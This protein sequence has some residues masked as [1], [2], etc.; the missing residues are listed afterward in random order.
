MSAEPTSH[1]PRGRRVLRWAL[2]GVFVV[3][4][5]VGVGVYRTYTDPVRVRR[6]AEAAI[7]RLVGGTCTIREASFSLLGGVRL[8]DVSIEVVGKQ[9]VFRCSQV[10]AE[11][12]PW[13]LIAGTFRWTK[14]TTIQPTLDILYDDATGETNLG[15]F[16]PGGRSAGS[17][18]NSWPTVELRD[19][20]IRFS[21][22]DDS[23]VRLL[24]ELTLTLRGR[25]TSPGQSA[26]DIVWHD[27]RDDRTG[28]T[29]WDFAAG[30]PRNI[31]GGLP[32]IS[33]ESVALAV[34]TRIESRTNWSDLLGIA[35]KVRVTDYNLVE[36]AENPRSITLALSGA[37][38]SVPCDVEE[39]SLPLDQR[40]LRFG[41]VSGEVVLGPD[42]ATVKFE[43]LFHGARCNVDGKVRRVGD[44]L[45][46]LADWEM[47][48]AAT[49]RSLLLPRG[50][51]SA[52]MEQ[53]RVVRAWPQLVKMQQDYDPH[54]AVDLD[55]AVRKAAGEEKIQATKATITARGGDASTR[56]FPYRGENLSG[57]VEYSPDGVKIRDVCGD[58]DQ[59]RVCVNGEFAR[60]DKCAAAWL[61]IT[62][63]KI[64]F[65]QELLVGLEQRYREIAEPFEIDAPLDLG[66]S[67]RRQECGAAESSPWD[68]EGRISF[69]DATLRHPR[70]SL[71][72]TQASGNIRVAPGQI[73]SL[74]LTSEIA[75]AVMAVTGNVD[76]LDNGVYD[77]S[78]RMQLEGVEIPSELD[79]FIPAAAKGIVQDL[80][81]SGRMNLDIGISSNSGRGMEF[82]YANI[83]TQSLNTNGAKIPVP[84]R[85]LHGMIVIESDQVRIGPLQGRVG[86]SPITL[87][88]TA[89][90]DGS[91]PSFDVVI[92]SPELVVGETLKAAFPASLR[93]AL[94]PWNI[95]DSIEARLHVWREADSQT[96]FDLVARLPGV[97][98]EHPAIPSPLRNVRGTIRADGDGFRSDDLTLDYA[99]T[100]ANV[101]FDFGRNTS[102]WRGD[103]S[104]VAAGVS[105]NDDL[106][107]A[108]PTMLRT[109]WDKVSPQGRIDVDRL[110]LL[111]E[112]PLEENATWS[113]DGDLQLHRVSLP[114]VAE[115]EQVDGLLTVRGALFD[116]QGGT[117]LGGEV[118]LDSVQL[119]GRAF[120]NVQSP[121]S[122]SRDAKG[123]VALTFAD[124][125]GEIYGGTVGGQLT[126][127]ADDRGAN[128]SASAMVYSMNLAPWID[129][130][131]RRSPEVL[132][133]S[134]EYRPSLVRGRA[135]LILNLSGAVG[136][137]SSRRGAGR[138]E[139][140]E[141]FLYRLPALLAVLSVVNVTLPKE[142][143]VHDAEAQ[144]Y[145]VGQEVFLEA[146]QMQGGPLTLVGSGIVSLP[147]QAVDL[148]LYANSTTALSHVPL[149]SDIIE[150]TT[151]E[152]IELRVT[153]PISRPTVRPTPFRGVS[154]ELK[155]LFQK[156]EKKPLSPAGR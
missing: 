53:Q 123:T 75:G 146:I 103:V 15:G 106:R 17:G 13:A 83:E 144:F 35:G 122:L 111:Y 121:W 112:R 12:D 23:S 37:S 88:G 86:G 95:G 78:Y 45:S 108:L 84:M 40:Y 19:A 8:G 131:R 71:P 126:L 69:K 134:A 36:T 93:E 129:A 132:E 153:G 125:R 25:A 82:L 52:P 156:K 135:N 32:A 152:L 4:V 147:D 77:G 26:Y 91:S 107:A 149:I 105:L 137:V 104:M 62:G 148:R 74:Y 87:E 14:L 1:P 133:G 81:I 130:G 120:T 154:E 117:A 70:L 79:S 151:K 85:S 142:E 11:H 59:G 89:S 61:R 98:V 76:F 56:W 110:K 24:E 99:E 138:V 67:L 39:R 145:L 46:S 128:Y 43:A 50:D 41:D 63:D 109:A 54:G 68:W 7:G 48:G 141:G 136:D 155:S 21:R 124:A 58:H 34:S 119:A 100:G 97:A 20:L 2:A 65:D 22:R 66:I 29:Q 57:T 38:L 51:A 30:L 55:V 16:Q 28:H 31:E 47:E 113:L 10:T 127:G 3:L 96:S 116:G 72:L 64:A 9:P 114:G 73:Q 60:P 143:F 115:V 33:M 101:S 92:H 27:Q 118:S 18:P 90:W 44:T 5:G 94:S 150:G 42:A 102:G 80:G 139:I 6:E 49:V 140:R